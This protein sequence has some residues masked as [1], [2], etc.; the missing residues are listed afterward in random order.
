MELNTTEQVAAAIKAV[1]RD[2]WDDL[3]LESGVP[4]ST[5]E[6]IAYAVTTNPSFDTMVGLVEALKRRANG[7][8]KSEAQ[9]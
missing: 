9:Q 7:Q 8:P 2:D 1:P 3:A 6:K 4:R 5:L